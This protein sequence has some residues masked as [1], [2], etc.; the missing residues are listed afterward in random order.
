V[1]GL[2]VGHQV[3]IVQWQNGTRRV[4][5]PPEQAERS[6]LLPLLFKT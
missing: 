2:Q 4:V 5:W 6:V 3:L 1:S